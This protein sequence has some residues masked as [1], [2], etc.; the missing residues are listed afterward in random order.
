MKI[1]EFFHR[2]RPV[3]SFEF[4]PPKNDTASDQLARVVNRL[5][6]LGPAFVSVTYGAG[7]STRDKTVGLVCSIKKDL[8]IETMAH[9]TCVGS[10]RVEIGAVLDRLRDGGVEN[11]LALRGD[12]PQGADRFVAPE[13][14]FAFAS[15]LTAFVRENYRFS[16]GGACYPESHV[17]SRSP[18]EDLQHLQLKVRA[19]SD[20][21]I[22]QLF[23]DPQVYF[24]FVA[25]A[26]AAGI[27]QPI[28]P[29]IMPVT[30]VEQ[31]ERFTSMCGASIPEALQQRLL[32]VRDRP[33]AVRRVGVE[34]ATQ[35]CSTLLEGGAP[36]IHFYTLNRSPSTRAIF[37]NLRTRGLL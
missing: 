29:G 4:F 28:V 35:Q 6:E 15:E 34:W 30:N 14:G 36:G 9:L 16:I 1:H 13:G 22:T 20:F 7:G 5:R 27:V 10:T 19:G 11:V 8:G 17:E 26:R 2:G 3:I 18:E 23:F 32:D 24:D 37:E 33:D 12:P 21:L 25:R 31:L